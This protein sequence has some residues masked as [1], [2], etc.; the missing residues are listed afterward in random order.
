MKPNYVGVAIKNCGLSL[1]DVLPEVVKVAPKLKYYQH[2]CLMYRRMAAGALLAGGD[3]QP[4][5]NYLFRS[6]RAFLH[7]LQTAP[8][9]E[10]VTSKSEPF[11]DAIACRDKE[12][13]K[14]IAKASRTTLAP[15]K[16]YEEDF[17]YM[18]ILMERF[19]L[20]A[21]PATLKHLLAE[22]AGFVGTNTDPHL[23]L[24]R[25][26]V[27]AD[28]EA[29]DEALAAAIDVRVKRIKKER[30]QETLHPDEAAT[31]AHVSPAVLAWLELAEAAG[32]KVAPDHPLAPR[33]ARLFHRIQ[34]PAPDAWRTAEQFST[35]RTRKTP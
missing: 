12:G 22:Y 3:P 8:D 34:F 13:A 21:S 11:L 20:G 4:F 19:Y 16:E 24:C 28:Q 26:L 14:A 9:E 27:A 1:E 10:K 25:A 5:Y 32:L 33:T 35:V 23:D 18:R 17:L 7:F 6:S 2:I 31:L 29:F 30:N 15:G